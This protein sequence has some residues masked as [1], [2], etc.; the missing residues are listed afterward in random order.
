M[1]AGVT[2]KG[3]ETEQAANHAKGSM[4]IFGRNPLELEIAADGAMGIAQVTDGKRPSAEA[5]LAL[6]AT[7]RNEADDAVGNVRKALPSRAA[8]R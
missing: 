5:Q 6:E 2:S 8:T 7:P 4:H 1:A 3:R